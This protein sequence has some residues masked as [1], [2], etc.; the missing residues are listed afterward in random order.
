[1]VGFDVTPRMPCSSMSCC[2][3]PPVAS[4]RVRLSYQGLC[5]KSSSRGIALAMS[6]SSGAGAYERRC[7]LDRVLGRDPELA[8]DDLPGRG[9]AE[10]VDADDIVGVTLPT[11]RHARFDRE[12]RHVGRQ[13]LGAVLRCLLLEP[14]PRRHRHDAGGD[15]I[16]GELLAGGE[17]HL[18][19]GPGPD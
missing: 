10:P 14:R 16:T 13:D 6:A 15:A 2:S 17:T 18:D 3:P 4:A 12:R 1:M 5:P 11:E 8:Q 9:C 19:L 7:P